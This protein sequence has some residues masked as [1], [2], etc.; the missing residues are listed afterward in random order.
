MDHPLDRL[1]GIG[2]FWRRG[3]IETEVVLSGVPNERP[4]VDEALA[5]AVAE[6]IEDDTAGWPKARWHLEELDQLLSRQPTW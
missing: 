4:V 2:A 3:E 1:P 5:I 6:V